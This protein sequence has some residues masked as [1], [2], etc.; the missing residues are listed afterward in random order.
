[1]FGGGTYQPLEPAGPRAQNLVAFA[2]G[3]P[4]G[5]MAV[6]VVPRLVSGLLDGARLPPEKFADTVVPVSGRFVDAFTGEE[7]EGPLRADKLFASLP[8]ALL[9]RDQVP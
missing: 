5:R 2:R 4:G 7:H 9:L 1:M 3:A 8:V 6:A